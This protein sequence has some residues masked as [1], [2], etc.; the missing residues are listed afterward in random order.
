M[1]LQARTETPIEVTEVQKPR[2]DLGQRVL[3]Q[4]KSLD[5]PLPAIVVGLDKC[6]AEVDEWKERN[7]V[8]SLK[9]VRSFCS[10]VLLMPLWVSHDIHSP[11]TALSC[12]VIPEHAAAST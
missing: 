6:C 11:Q 9:L 12:C 8:S 10:T 3:V 2:Y 7:S 5:K 4:D 1:H